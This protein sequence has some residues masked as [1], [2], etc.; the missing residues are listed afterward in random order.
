MVMGTARYQHRD[1][2]ARERHQAD[3]RAR[4]RARNRAYSRLANLHPH[5]WTTLYAAA[6]AEEGITPDTQA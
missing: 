2:E 1:E 5:E 4:D 6:L 3:M